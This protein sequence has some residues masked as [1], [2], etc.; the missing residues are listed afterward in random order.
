MASLD[1]AHKSKAARPVPVRVNGI[2]IPRA[3]I[4]SEA[5]HHPAD[6][7]A[8][9]RRLATQALVIR[10]LLTQEAMRLGIVAVPLRDDEGRRE[11]D[12]EARIRAL[13][14]REVVTPAADEETCRRYYERNCKRFRSE[15]LHGVSHILIAA[16]RSDEDAWQRA[17]DTARRLA[18]ALADA[19]GNAFASAAREYSAC[20]SA[21]TGGNLGQ[22]GPG[23]TVPEFEAALAG[24]IP[25][26]THPEPVE[27]RYGFH[28][29][30][31]ER[32]VEA[33]DLPFEMVRDRIAEWLEETVRRRAMAQYIG[34]L[35]SRA[36][37]EG[38]SLEMPG[39]LAA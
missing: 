19:D 13:V 32:R 27:T 1:I 30:R 34:V 24:M 14:E 35:A 38:F 12:D 15:P 7:P 25:G 2:E 10:E 5:Q 28:V 3:A 39:N 23:Q 20:P 6:G 29:V 17:R 8:E 21:A 26:V 33:R 9:A 36:R 18:M 4:G 22:I 31:L 37:I 16:I 11:T